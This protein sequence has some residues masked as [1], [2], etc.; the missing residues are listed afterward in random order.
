MAKVLHFDSG[1]TNVHSGFRALMDRIS[2]L[3]RWNRIKL[4]TANS[5]WGQKNYPFND[6]FLNLVNNDYNAE[7]RCVDFAK[8]SEA[9]RNDINSWIKHATDGKIQDL[10]RE[11]QIEPLTRLMLC[12]AVYFKGKWQTQFKTSDTRDGPFYISSSQTVTVPMMSLKARFR[13][14]RSDDGSLK[15][16]EMPYIGDDLSMIILMPRDAREW[17]VTN[18][19]TLL[20]IEAELTPENLRAWLAN[21]DKAAAY[22]KI[23]SVPRFATTQSFNLSDQL[24]SMGMPSAFDMDKADFSGM[25]GT[26][27]LYISAVLHKA[28]VEVNEEGTEAAAATSVIITLRGIPERFIADHPFI[29][30]I[31]DKGS[32]AILFMG[33]MVDP[34]K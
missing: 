20:D 33:R 8:A 7:A 3:Q 21:L 10:I 34:T 17:G 26:R 23:I 1:Q 6:A 2:D 29:F 11:G 19:A 28:F 12:N 16:L 24:K 30:L 13:T 31:R 15:L 18:E 25:D 32:G 9:A 22:E 5:L 4:I 14:A 27:E